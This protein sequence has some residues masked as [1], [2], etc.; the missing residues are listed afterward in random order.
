M[1]ILYLQFVSFWLYQQLLLPQAYPDKLQ[2]YL[3]NAYFVNGNYVSLLHFSGITNV[4]TYYKNRLLR[5]CQK[6]KFGSRICNVG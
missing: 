3:D 4:R 6:R 1:D 5:M 2:P